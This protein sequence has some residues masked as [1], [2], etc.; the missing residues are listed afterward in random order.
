MWEYILLFILLVV[1]GAILYN[2]RGSIVRTITG[3]KSNT[4][5]NWWKQFE[6]D[7]NIKIL[8]E[9][10]SGGNGTAYLVKRGGEKL[11]LKMEK[12]DA[13][14]KLKPLTS[15]YFRQLEF[16]KLAK[17]HPD[18]FTTL[19]DHGMIQNCLYVHPNIEGLREKMKGERL[20]RLNR[21]NS[22][23]DC[24]WLLCGPM[25]DG[26]LKDVMVDVFADSKK[27]ANFM[28]QMLKIIDII[29]KEG[30][31]Q[32]DFGP[33]N[34]MFKKVKS[35][36]QWYLIDYGNI[37]NV[38]FPESLLDKDISTRPI[39]NND[40]KNFTMSVAT[41][42][43]NKTRIDKKDILIPF[44]EYLKKVE[45]SKEYSKIKRMYKENNPRLI[46]NILKIEFPTL[47]YQLA[48]VTPNDTILPD[49]HK[50]LFRHILTSHI[51]PNAKTIRS[52][53]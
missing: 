13:Y 33:S 29:R 2:M 20:D 39:V 45:K 42:M 18:K 36:Y 23:P 38:R 6:K 11:V 34:I 7:H 47:A 49:F 37:H 53:M 30:Y 15:E 3:G 22:Q 9:I 17:K 26:T 48:L 19:V 41:H 1:V 46:A 14:D 21:K 10:A 52:L 27:F 28:I 40:L 31:S 8:K 5:I 51:I 25:L 4:K 24:Y 50:K 32:N 44:S 43:F 16:D 12:M 35:G